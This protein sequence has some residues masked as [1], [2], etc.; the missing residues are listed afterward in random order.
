MKFAGARGRACR[1]AG[2][3]V[4]SALCINMVLTTVG[5]AGGKDSSPE[6]PPAALAQTALK[7]VV[8]PDLSALSAPAERQLRDAFAAFSR[9]LENSQASPGELAAAYDR[10]GQLL[11]AA[12][13][14]DEAESCYL[15]AQQLDPEDL[16]W[17]YLLGHVYLFKGNRKKAAAAFTRALAIKPDDVPTLV[18]LGEI[19][20]DEGDAQAAESLFLKAIS[21]DPRSAAPLVDAGRAAMARQAYKEAVG[22][23]ERALALDS[24]A[25]AIHYPL[26][27]A[28]R[29]LGD[30]DRSAAHL[31]R[32]GETWPALPD[33]VMQQRENALASVTQYER[34][35]AQALDAGEWAA[36]A[37]AFRKGLELEPDNA[38]L[39]HRLGTALYG[40]GDA[41]GAVREFEET[42]RRHP[43]FTK[44][45][46]SLGMVSSLNGRPKDAIEQ[47]SAALRL[48]PNYPEARLGLAEALRMSGRPDA[49][50]PQYEQAI[51]LDPGI[52]ESWIGGGLALVSLGRYP[53]AREWLAQAK[54]VHPD[55]P[56]LAQVGALIP[57]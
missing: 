50:V 34:R 45:Y 47:F 11:L 4:I 14:G 56:E 52:V 33:P 54:H 9:S 25:S 40:A 41:A 12:E 48:D 57:R 38:S 21:L 46:F 28:Y 20:L 8:L 1:A 44:A 6:G 39:R 26:S 24:H 17:P 53:Q 31:S 49:A 3:S 51:K 2:A 19:R 42:L 30:R 36:A 23:F 27:M 7:P 5:C 35:G 22:Y 16:R 43:D 32:R 10:L 13:L 37:E 29:A 15:H 18:R 55:Q